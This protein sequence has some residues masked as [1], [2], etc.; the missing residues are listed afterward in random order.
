M[1]L[2]TKELVKELCSASFV[3]GYEITEQNNVLLGY[4][5]QH[6]IPYEIDSIGNIIF[7]KSGNGEE[8]L[9]LIAHYDEIG[10]A[11]KYIDDNGYVYFSASGGVDASILRS[12]KVVIMHDG[13]PVDGVIGAK[14]IH[15]TNQKRSE[16]NTLDISDLWI[17]I[18]VIGKEDV[19]KYVSVGDPISFYPNFA[20]LKDRI[21]TSKSIDN[22]VGVAVLFSVYEKIRN[23]NVNYKCIYFVLSS[24]EELG[25]RGA[26]IAGYNIYPEVCI[27]IDVTH[28]TDYPSVSKSK[29]GDIKLNQGVVIPTGSNFT[30]SVQ[31]C[32]R[33][34]AD[35][36]D[37][38]YQV[39][40]LPGYS[41]TDISEIQLA[42][43]GCRSGLISV[44][45]RYMH[46]SVEI[47]SYNDI[48]ASVEVL[49]A[50][51]M[52]E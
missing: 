33:K 19:G 16:K 45:C 28:A 50:F 4:L 32:L 18:G 25:L 23:A 42:R 31:K 17:D 21:F 7:Q 9:M 46:T 41:G 20:E 14:P 30:P 49:S 36:N 52:G 29:Y 47:A 40:S 44:P 12:Q 1:L 13:Q 34:N 51:C 26:R 38:P 24:Q 37:I 15:M 2:K 48:E 11:V 8:T 6:N 35:K 43:G 10:F 39:E 3:S 5:Q 22:R 27:A